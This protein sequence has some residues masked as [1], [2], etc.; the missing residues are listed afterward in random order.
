MNLLLIVVAV[1]AVFK[2]ADG[3]KKGMIKEI[4]SLVSMVVLCLVA[5]LI[6][7]GA[8]GYMTGKVVG[9]VIAVILLC[10]IGIV[11]HLLSVV[12]F[13]AKVIARLP[14]IHFVD[15]LL[16]AVFGVFEVVLIL[17]TVYAFILMGN[18]G[19]MSIVANII[20]EY[21]KES[22]ILLWIYRHNLV[23][24]G[25]DRI[26]GDARQLPW[27]LWETAVPFFH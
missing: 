19:N 18:P 15:K 8:K 5:G 10:L 9:V 26:M 11:H 1:A 17:W 21:T 12:F 2:L 6:A 27:D 4:I 24:V 7:I 13:S 25:I 20:S 3:Y 22:E 16:G 14:V 23:V